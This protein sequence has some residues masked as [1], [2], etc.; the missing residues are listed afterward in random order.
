MDELKKDILIKNKE[1]AEFTLR[2]L[3]DDPSITKE[4]LDTLRK[5]IELDNIFLEN[6]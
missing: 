3:K 5:V 4:Y 1:M 2:L 6:Q